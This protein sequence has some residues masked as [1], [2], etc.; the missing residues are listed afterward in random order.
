[1]VTNLLW[2]QIQF[3]LYSKG[4]QIG[5]KIYLIMLS[6]LRLGLLCLDVV[7]YPLSLFSPGLVC[8]SLFD[9]FAKQF[10]PKI[11]NKDPVR[12]WAD[13]TSH[14][15]RS[16]VYPSVYS[17]SKP[18]ILRNPKPSNIPTTE[19]FNYRFNYWISVV[20]LLWIWNWQTL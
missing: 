7:S 16:S 5:D 17:A 19:D 1:M 11:G 13:C 10:H 18:S 15:S 4:S 2:S 12:L 9:L 14:G 20:G 6:I 8:S 3:I